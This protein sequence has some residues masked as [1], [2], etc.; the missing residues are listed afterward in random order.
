MIWQEYVYALQLV[1]F[2]PSVTKIGFTSN[3]DARLKSHRSSMAGWEVIML[4]PLDTGTARQAEAWLKKLYGTPTSRN[5][6]TYRF[7]NSPEIFLLP[8]QE[9]A[10]LEMLSPA[11]FR[12]GA[13]LTMPEPEELLEMPIKERIA[14]MLQANGYEVFATPNQRPP[15]DFE[16]WRAIHNIAPLPK[17]ASYQSQTANEQIG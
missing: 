17:I 4:L 11:F 7:K 5:P 14:E 8:H 2:E 3:I 1:G 9:R 15:E 12:Y 10:F 16:F 6:G 13:H